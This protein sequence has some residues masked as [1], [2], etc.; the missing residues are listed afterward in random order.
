MHTSDISTGQSFPAKL[1]EQSKKKKIYFDDVFDKLDKKARA[2]GIP[3][4]GQFELTP[5]C[6]FDCKMCYSHL[7]HGQLQGDS[8]L[9][10]EQ[11]KQII[12]EAYSAGLMR[13]ILTGGECLTYPGFKEIYLYLH[14]LGCEIRV[15]TNGALLDDNW[16]SF[17]LAHPPI[18]IQISLYGYD[19]D[20]Y[21]KVTGH[22][23]FSVVSGN[24]RN[25]IDA[26]LPVSLAITP[27]KYMGKGILD[28]IRFANT[29]NI[30][31]SMPPFLI[32]PKEET[33]RSG[34]DH[35]IDI[36]LYA[37]AY[38][39]NEELDGKVLHSI[40]PELL[41]PPGG[42]Y[43]ECD[44][45]GL[46]CSGGMSRFDI[47]WNGAMYICNYNRSVICHPLTEGFL[48]S[49]NRIHQAAL[50]WKR[51]PECI[52]CPY[53]PVC[54]TCEIA[55]AKFGKNGQQMPFVQCNQT[56]LLVQQGVYMI[57]DHA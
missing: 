24:I 30:P 16:I 34:R 12:D 26:G 38:K 3:L 39:L 14:S 15:L 4:S 18:L 31:Y 40:D 50:N 2:K 49:W 19:D 17:F 32:D 7:T 44:L 33:G 52:G 1:K 54:V 8:L 13:V 22:R 29:F 9:T 21:E 36:D 23:M 57:Q 27:S 43:H 20:S 6:N 10:A 11:W 47:D 37:E 5:L 25:V 46:N 48:S 51:V 41:P 53:E 55:K 45:L 35:N 42:P 28:T 56:K